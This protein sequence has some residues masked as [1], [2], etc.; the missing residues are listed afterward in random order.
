MLLVGFDDH[1]EFKPQDQTRV[2]SIVRPLNKSAGFD[3][4][5]ERLFADVEYT[6]ILAVSLKKSQSAAVSFTPGFSPVT[7]C[8]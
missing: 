1:A 7:R 8:H 4:R 2:T 5:T 3:R 6:I